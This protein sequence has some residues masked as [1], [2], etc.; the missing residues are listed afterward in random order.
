MGRRE[1]GSEE[2]RRETNLIAKAYIR[3]FPSK[4]HPP[5]S[6]LLLP[7]PSTPPSQPGQLPH[8]LH[9]PPLSLLTYL[10]PV[11]HFPAGTGTEVASLGGVRPLHGCAVGIHPGAALHVAPVGPQPARGGT[12]AG[13]EH[14]A[15][16][17]HGTCRRSSVWLRSQHYQS[18]AR[19]RAKGCIWAGRAQAA[20]I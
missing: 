13:T 5:L 3:P 6:L 7:P 4:P 12:L 8:P 2:G 9:T 10:A 20:G 1:A 15:E 11:A 19:P 18:C 17:H 14:R 16:T